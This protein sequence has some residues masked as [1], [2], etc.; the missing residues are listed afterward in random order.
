[1]MAPID[2]H[3]KEKEYGKSI[4]RDKEFYKS[5]EI[6]EGVARSLRIEGKGKVPNRARSLSNEEV[7]VLWRGRQLGGST[8]RSLVQ[9]MWW[10]NCLHFAMRSREEHY[11]ILME[12]FEIK[13]DEGGRKYITFQEGLT[14]TRSAGLNFKQ[15]LIFPECTKLSKKLSKK[16]V[17]G[18]KTVGWV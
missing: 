1:M 15:R 9:T 16:R 12:D 13:F 5:R 8:P 17:Y 18:T 11:N 3:L 4:S 7:E 6:L 14:K 2:R 10:N